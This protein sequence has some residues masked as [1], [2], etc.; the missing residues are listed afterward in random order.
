MQTV[1]WLALADRSGR[2][3]A[4]RST[5]SGPWTKVVRHG[6]V[7]IRDVICVPGCASEGIK[8]LGVVC[9]LNLSFG[10]FRAKLGRKEGVERI[11]QR[12]QVFRKNSGA[13][14]DVDGLQ[15][16]FQVQ[17]GWRGPFPCP[18]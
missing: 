17:N 1:L 2:N 7:R 14:M 12:R 10:L 4:D 18:F 15:Q 5:G 13:R 11:G 3:D 8:E 16:Q 6:G 9:Q